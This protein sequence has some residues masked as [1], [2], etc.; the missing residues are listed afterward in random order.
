M[1]TRPLDQ[2]GLGL[3]NDAVLHEVAVI[4]KWFALLPDTAAIYVEWK[5]IVRRHK[6]QV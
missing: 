2:N 5:E 4:E 6:V 1:A 3:S